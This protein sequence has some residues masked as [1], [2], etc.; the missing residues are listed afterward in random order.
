MIRCNLS[1]YMG[2]QK[3]NISDVARQTGLNR[4]TISLLYHERASRIELDTIEKLCGV[5]KCELGD[6]LEIKDEES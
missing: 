1:R 2:E 4:S 3:M 6:L 5:F